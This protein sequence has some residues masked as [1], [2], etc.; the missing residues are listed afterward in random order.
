M[1]HVGDDVDDAAEQVDAMLGKILIDARRSLRANR[2]TGE[3]GQLVRNILAKEIADQVDFKY[4]D[5]GKVFDVKS[6]E[7]IGKT[8]FNNQFCRHDLLLQCATAVDAPRYEDGTLDEDGLIRKFTKVLPFIW[9]DMIFNLPKLI[10]ARLGRESAIAE[11]FRAGIAALF[12]GTNSWSLAKQGIRREGAGASCDGGANGDTV[13]LAFKSSL[14][15]RVHELIEEHRRDHHGRLSAGTKWLP[16]QGSVSAWWRAADRPEWNASEWTPESPRPDALPVLA[17]RYELLNQARG[18]KLEGIKTQ[19]K[20]I[21]LGTEFGVFTPVTD[22]VTEDGLIVTDRMTG[23]HR[24]AVLSQEF[25]SE[26]MA[27]PET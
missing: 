19:K 3:Q 13:Q 2:K 8:Q 27:M 14:V 18:A 15:H 12:T 26:L 9:G 17:M 10:D 16:V 23:G 24:L 4:I 20:L 21:Q 22:G 5:G 25:T 6:D 7:L 11:E 1:A